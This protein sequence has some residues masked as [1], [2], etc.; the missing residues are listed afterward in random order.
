MKEI[1]LMILAGV[2]VDNLALE[3]FLGVSPLMG[4]YRRKDKLLAMGLCVTLVML[5][6]APLCTMV[7]AAQANLG[8]SHLS[9]FTNVLIILAVVAACDLVVRLGKKGLG[10]YFPLIALNSA[11]LGLALLNAIEGY[12]ILVS[13]AAA[14]GAGLGF[15]LALFLISGV[16]SRVDQKAV[17]AAF[18]GLPITLLACSILA[19]ALVAF[20]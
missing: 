8:Q 1:L 10:V 6:S 3:Q 4:C 14:V 9:L 20:K 16:M 7:N 2:L 13:M 12:D 18:R 17:P 11:V 5:I 15:T 19:M